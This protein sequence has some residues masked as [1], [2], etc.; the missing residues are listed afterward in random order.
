VKK[1]KER[2]KEK[3]E[4]KQKKKK[5]KERE[6]KKEWNKDRKEKTREVEK[7][8]EEERGGWIWCFLLCCASC[9]WLVTTS[10]P[11]LTSLAWFSL[12]PAQ[13]RHWMIIQLAFI[14]NV[15]LVHSLFQPTCSSTYSTTAWQVL[16]LRHRYTI[17]E[18]AILLV[19]VPSC[20]AW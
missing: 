1:V 19:V 8:E 13:Y 20:F 17:F 2:K 9:S 4:E 7:E 12:G 15:V 16:L 14:T 18:V 5:K 10:V 3:E 6:E 11:R